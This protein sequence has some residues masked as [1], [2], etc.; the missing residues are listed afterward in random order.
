VLHGT[1]HTDMSYSYIQGLGAQ[2]FRAFDYLGF[3]YFQIDDPLETFDASQIVAYARRSAVPDE[4]AASFSS[5]D[6]TLNA[7]FALAQHSALFGSQEQFID[8]PTR[9]KG[10][11]LQDSFNI[12]EAAMSA[13]GEQ[14]LTR[15]A[16][17]EFAASGARY[18]PDGRLN[19]IY[20]SGQGARDIPDFTEIYPEWV[21]QYYL[22]TGD[23]GLLAQV[24]PVVV[25]LAGYVA[26]AIDPSTGLVVNLPGGSGGYL[27]GVVDNPPDMRYGYD[28]ATTARTTVNLLAVDV[29]QRVAQIAGVLSR[30]GSEQDLQRQRQTALTEAVNARLTRPDG[31]YIDGLYAD[32]T[33]S[34]HASEHANAYA[35]AFGVVPSGRLEVVGRYLAGLGM[36]MGP[37][38][39]QQLLAALHAAGRDGD[40]VR[41]LTDPSQ[42]GWANVL[43]RGGTFTWE[44]WEPSD[45]NGDSMSHGWGATVLPEIQQA[46]LGVT[47]T[48]PGFATVE[49][50]PPVSTSGPSWASGKVPTP[51]GDIAVR[52]EGP[53]VATGVATGGFRLNIT[54]PAGVVATVAVPAA[55]PSS[56]GVT[57]GGRPLDQV[58]GVRFLRMAGGYALVAVGAGT[59]SFAS[60]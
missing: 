39:A 44:T 21:W 28:M 6:A 34:G 57:E 8:T 2:T 47:P 10:P 33:P 1:Q 49:V 24:Y 58:G 36:A 17:L 46:V 54:L 48:G 31:V 38:T 27:Y 32:G 16:L 22:H 29:F 50:R 40:L 25:N 52:W 55:G 37:M 30:P 23:R 56:A 51:R 15:R 5:S 59:Y 18:W 9:E 20:P 11:F 42:P 19:A 26:H 35:V 7:V 14:N 13:F 12:S 53:G 60:G 4:Q 3:R 41:L 43:A 45:A